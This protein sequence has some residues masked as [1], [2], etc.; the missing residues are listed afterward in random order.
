LAVENDHHKFLGYTHLTGMTQAIER[1][2]LLDVCVTAFKVWVSHFAATIFIYVIDMGQEPKRAA[3]VIIGIVAICYLGFHWHGK[4][5]GHSLIASL[6]LFLVS[7]MI[8]LDV[9]VAIAD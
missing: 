1:P 7:G 5:L 4:S 9:A 3:T 2:P 8:A 6:I